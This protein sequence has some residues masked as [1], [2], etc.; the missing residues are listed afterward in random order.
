[1]I[2]VV[3]AAEGLANRY[4]PGV[5]SIY[6]VDFLSAGIEEALF[7]LGVSRSADMDYFGKNRKDYCELDDAVEGLCEKYFPGTSSLYEAGVLEGEIGKLIVRLGG[8]LNA[9]WYI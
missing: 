9:R 1:M 8:S 3:E 7:L 6:E 5:P 4:L 2:S